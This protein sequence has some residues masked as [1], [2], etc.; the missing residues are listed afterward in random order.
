MSKEHILYMLDDGLQLW[1]KTALR[2]K[3][4]NLFITIRHRLSLAKQNPKKG[5]LKSELC[6]QR[7]YNIKS[8]LGINAPKC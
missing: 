1:D 7:M 8:T 6:K 4:S 2:I 3:Y 5:A